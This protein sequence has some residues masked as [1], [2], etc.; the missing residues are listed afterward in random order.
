METILEFIDKHCE[1]GIHCYKT[2]KVSLDISN[3]DTVA[4]ENSDQ[5]TV[6]QDTSGKIAVFR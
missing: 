6:P 5:D 1:N 3:T 2:R 4:S